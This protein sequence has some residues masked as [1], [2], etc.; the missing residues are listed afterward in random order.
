MM[1]C[2]LLALS[3]TLL[4]PGSQSQRVSPFVSPKHFSPVTVPF[5]YFN[6]H[7]YIS[8]TLNGQPGMVF[9]LD[10]GTSSN[11]LNMRTSEALGLK[12][13]SVKPKNG[14]GL[15]S[16][17]V[18]V[19]AAKD[20][21]ARIGGIQVANLMA[22]ID[23]QDL[24]LHLGHP[25]DGILGFPFLQH[26]AVVLDFDKHSLTLFPSRRFRYRGPGDRL[27]LTSKSKSTSIPVVLVTLGQPQRRAQV[28]IDTGS[29]VTLLLSRDYVRG[30]HLDGAFVS[31]PNYQLYGLGGYFS[32]QSGLLQS[33]LMG[34]IEAGHLEIF[35]MQN[36][37]A[38]DSR[39]DSAGMIGTSFLD[40]F[41]KIVFDVP[42]GS[43]I[44]ELKPVDQVPASRPAFP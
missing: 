5:E 25:I 38:E 29:A 33:L 20:I 9:M 28:E 24:A 31:M 23:L 2:L 7:I 32:V 8:L 15:G 21:D 10:S 44:F 30:A 1:G 13:V 26:F 40:Q 35:Q 4:P 34:R 41:Q 17:R 39:K 37:P 18:F 11:I 36:D 12:P 22:V 14:L 16:G 3:T 6:R 19:A 42:G 43:V 27:W